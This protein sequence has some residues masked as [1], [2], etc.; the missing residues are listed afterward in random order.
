MRRGSSSGKIAATKTGFFEE[1]PV[2]AIKA[3]ILDQKKPVFHSNED[4]HAGRDTRQVSYWPAFGLIC[5]LA[6][7]VRFYALGQEDYWLDELHSMANSAGKRGEFEA[8]PYGVIVWHYQR[9]T[10]LDSS[11]TYQSVWTGM[12]S[13][14]HPPA[15]FLLLR[16]WRGFFGDGEAAVRSLSAAF[17]VL[18]ILPV[19]LLFCAA[20]RRRAGVWAGAILA[21]AATHVQMAQQNRPYSLSILLTSLS[22]LLLF[23]GERAWNNHTSRSSL[24]FA[25]GYGL[26]VYLAVLTHYFAGL[27]L[28]GQAAYAGLRLRGRALTTWGLVVFFSGILAGLTWLSVFLDQI[29][30]IRAQPWLLES[31]P[32]HVQRSFLR[33]LDLPIRLLFWCE[34]FQIS[35]WRSMAGLLVAI[36]IAVILYRKRGT[37]SP[38]FPLFLL[39]FLIPVMGLLIFDLATG[40]QLLSHL[41]YAA[42]ATPGLAGLIALAVDHLRP[43]LRVVTFGALVVVMAVRLPMPAITNPHA[44][45][46]ARQLRDRILEGD[47]VI[48]DAVGWPDYWIPHFFA[49]VHY[50]SPDIRN[51][52][53]LLREPC[54]TEVGDR[55]ATFER[56]FVVSPRID[57]VPAPTTGHKLESRSGYIEQIGWI[58]LFVKK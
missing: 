51:P 23:H 49:T 4:G 16:V 9:T 5:L 45:I 38:L 35:V 40:K 57:A 33:F 15:Y 50:Y 54:S 39:W 12:R 34:P 31:S 28:L 11:S 22:V 20:G 36:A 1:T 17:S 19:W 47:L 10:D 2:Y 44:R 14:S 32:D 18:S 52:F 37:L 24:W 13:D 55:V 46:A 29:G 26:S 3:D 58:Y 27:A 6:A 43:F 53:L 48:Y 7:G 42:L 41:R 21:L 25:V 56:I 8:A 30:F